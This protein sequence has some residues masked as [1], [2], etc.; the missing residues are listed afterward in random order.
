MVT[1]SGTSLPSENGPRAV[2]GRL[3]MNHK[4]NQITNLVVNLDRVWSMYCLRRCVKIG[5]LFLL[6]TRKEEK[7]TVSNNG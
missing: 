4:E 7:G 2:I 3:T 6:M 5:F 1:S